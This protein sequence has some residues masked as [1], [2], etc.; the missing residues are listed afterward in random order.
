VLPAWKARL[1]LQLFYC[2]GTRERLRGTPGHYLNPGTRDC[3]WNIVVTFGLPKDGFLLAFHPGRHVRRRQRDQV[4]VVHGLRSKSEARE[5][6]KQ[7]AQLI[8]E[9][10]R[11]TEQVVVPRR[12]RASSRLPRSNSPRQCS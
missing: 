12:F 7:R 3:G 6:A 9:Q 8:S 11:E 10:I 4:A 2:P 5:Q 1:F